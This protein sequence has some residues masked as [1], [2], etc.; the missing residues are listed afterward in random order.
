MLYPR[1]QVVHAIKRYRLMACRLVRAQLTAMFLCMMLSNAVAMQHA[2]EHQTLAAM[3]QSLKPD[4]TPQQLG[5]LVAG[6]VRLMCN[7]DCELVATAASFVTS[8]AVDGMALQCNGDK[9]QDGATSAPSS[10]V[11]AAAG[12]LACAA[13]PPRKK[14][15]ENSND[16]VAAAMLLR[17]IRSYVRGPLAT[18]GTRPAA[19]QAKADTLAEAMF[20]E[21]LKES[22][23][24]SA[25]SRLTGLNSDALQRGGTLQRSNSELGRCEQLMANPRAIRSDK[26]DL[27]WVWEWFHTH[28]PDVEPDKALKRSYKR[29]RAFIAGACHCLFFKQRAL[30]LIVILYFREA[31]GPHLRAEDPD[32]TTPRGNQKFP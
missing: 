22:H 14:H 27:D 5:N 25:A 1:K 19:L 8:L 7:D 4:Q 6:A 16:D 18:Q 32:G 11:E 15:K 29:K 17:N 24:M 28:S 9:N 21:E 31:P 12:L 30:T 20:S 23:L 10:A 26:V 3:L 2:T 13:S